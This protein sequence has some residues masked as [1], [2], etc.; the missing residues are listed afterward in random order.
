MNIKRPDP[1]ALPHRLRLVLLALCLA[2]GLPSASEARASAAEVVIGVFAYQ[3]EKAALADW[4]PVRDYLNAS[5]PG[6]HFRL[7]RYE[8]DGL[9]EAIRAARVD[10]V[11][12]NPGYYVAMEHEFGI[13]RIATLDAPPA[14]SPTQAIGSTV[15]A[16]ADHPALR[17]LSDLRG[18]TLAA[19]APEAFG[20]YLLVARELLKQG[21][22]PEADLAEIRFLGLPMDRIVDAVMSGKADAGIVRA[23]LPEQLTREGALPADALRVLG[24]LAEPGFP[25][26][27]STPLYPDWPIAV[28]RHFDPALAKR[29]AQALLSMPTGEGRIGWSVAADYQ[30]VHDVYRELRSGP[31][32]HLREIAPGEL[33]RRFWPA[34]LGLAALLLAWGVH[35]VR[36]E[37]LVQ[38]RT[39]ELRDSL[40]AREEAETRIRRSQ[41]QMEHLSRLSILGELSGSLAHEIN[42]PLTTIGN[43]ARSL[44]RRHSD[45]RL[46]P[47]ALVEACSEIGSEAERAG[48]IVRRIRHFARKRAAVREEVD[49]ADLAEEARRL[50]HGMLVQAPEIVIEN[51]AAERCRAWADGPQLQQV[52][53]NLLKN[54]I[55]A[56]RDEPP[57]RQRIRVRIE[58]V[59]RRLWLHVIDRGCGI[60]ADQ[61]PHLFESFF[62]TKADGLGLGLSICKSIVEAHGGRLSAHPNTDGPGMT[63]S[64]SLPCH[65]RTD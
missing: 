9:R 12:T 23:C 3:G 13:S 48:G 2:S 32:A 40:R 33:L 8:P 38:R 25:C 30:P 21:I 56:G 1:A 22:D 57:G 10:L 45:G 19:V 65:E 15:I 6:V 42:Q 43:Y 18:R 4:A 60:A 47:A 14:L 61:M 11:I 20:G 55:D 62:T 29:V 37:H 24:P 64:V 51:A 63:F 58:A 36:V 34:L 44:L 54:A 50:I 59:E 39:A 31:Y 26:A 53:L 16:R 7:D 17:E 5:L 41:E 27:L 28:T 49:L 35:T 46:T 52:L